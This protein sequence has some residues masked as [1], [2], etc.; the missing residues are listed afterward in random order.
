MTF[1]ILINQSSA[2][3]Q[4]PYTAL[5]FCKALI[6]KQQQIQQVF[7]FLDG[8]YN[9]SSFNI[10]AQDETNLTQAWQQ[11]AGQHK[12]ELCACVATSL[13]R[14]IIDANEAQ[15]YDKDHFNL[16]KNFKLAGLGQLFE[17]INQS[18][19]FIQFG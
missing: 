2:S 7:F 19:R 6:A 3:A 13:R 15:R 18:D 11:L 1:T 10:L 9:A 8:V 4:A 5:N 12:F 14:G 16:A 17:A